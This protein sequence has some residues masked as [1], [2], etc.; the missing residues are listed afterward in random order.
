MS[1]N[2]ILFWCMTKMQK[3]A[4]LGSC[5]GSPINDNLQ[6]G[7][8]DFQ[9]VNVEL[10]TDGSDAWKIDFQLL[11]FGNKVASGSHSDL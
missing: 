4:W 8:E 2:F 5:P 3:E 11:K 7:E 10:L 9:S 1:F 6:F